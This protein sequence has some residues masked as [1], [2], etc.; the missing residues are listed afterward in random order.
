[1]IEAPVA[2]S[3]SPPELNFDFGSP[4][5][6]APAPK[7]AP[8]SP[9]T[10]TASVRRFFKRMLDGTP[11]RSGKIRTVRAA[12]EWPRMGVDDFFDRLLDPGAYTAPAGESTAD[13]PPSFKPSS[14][15][16]GA[17]TASQSEVFA[18]FIWSN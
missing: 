16:A 4:S 6:P 18:G 15:S 7:P 8:V 1:M 5:R 11:Q 12:G 14:E 3:S 2:P 17:S 13:L 10:A 9:E